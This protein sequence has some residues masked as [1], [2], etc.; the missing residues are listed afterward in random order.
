MFDWRYLLHLS[1]KRLREEKILG[2]V[3]GFKDENV[4]IMPFTTVSDIAPGWLVESTEK[5][6]DI[7]VGD[8]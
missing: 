8:H 6:L 5:P 2:E 4:Y 1:E 7:K 3:V